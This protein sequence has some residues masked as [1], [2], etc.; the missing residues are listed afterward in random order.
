MT[1]HSL[2]ATVL[3]TVLIV[4]GLAGLILRARVESILTARLEAAEDRTGPLAHVTGAALGLRPGRR[5][6]VLIGVGWIL[7]GVAMLAV[8][9]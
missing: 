6:I 2:V 1:I 3:A 4:A 7:I 5:F 9:L 8:L